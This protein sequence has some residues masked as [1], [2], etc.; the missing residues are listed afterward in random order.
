MLASSERD[1]SVIEV[2]GRRALPLLRAALAVTA[3]CA[4]KLLHQHLDR[5]ALAAVVALVLAYLQL[6]AAPHLLALVQRPLAERLGALA[7]RLDRDPARALVVAIAVADCDA[8]GPDRG[9]IRRV[10]HLWRCGQSAR[11]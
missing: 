1:D 8:A 5:N 9:A 3:G 4:A 2:I 11:K 10:L 7:K 6:A